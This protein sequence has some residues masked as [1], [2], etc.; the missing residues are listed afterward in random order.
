[1][2]LRE[3]NFLMPVLCMDLCVSNSLWVPKIHKHKKS[4]RQT[5]WY[6]V[7]ICKALFFLL[8]TDGVVFLTW[9]SNTH[10][11]HLH[12]PELPTISRRTGTD[13]VGGRVDR[14]CRVRTCK[15]TVHGLVLTSRQPHAR[16]AA[17]K[18]RAN[19]PAGPRCQPVPLQYL[20]PTGRPGLHGTRFHH[21]PSGLARLAGWKGRAGRSQPPRKHGRRSA[22]ESGETHTRQAGE[23]KRAGLDSGPPHRRR[24]VLLLQSYRVVSSS[25]RPG[26][27]SRARTSW[28]RCG[29]KPRDSR[30]RSPARWARAHPRTRS[31]PFRAAR[32]RGLW[33]ARVACLPAFAQFV[34]PVP[35]GSLSRACAAPASGFGVRDSPA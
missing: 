9:H 26:L 3:I 1:M 21:P 35:L 24:L 11:K 33:I 4:C 16:A 14:A 8:L 15:R 31:N 5:N 10:S 6:H 19:C 29:S 20:R 25:T 23:E 32:D 30:S 13:R 17:T 7:E 2:K 28:R 22:T 18:V 27:C 34:P 12:I